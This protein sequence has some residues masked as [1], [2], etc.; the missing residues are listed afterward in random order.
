LL[1]GGLRW[2][3]LAFSL[4]G[5]RWRGFA[6]FILTLLVGLRLPLVRLIGLSFTLLGLALPGWRLTL[7]RLTLWLPLL[8]LARLRLARLRLAS[9]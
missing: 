5:F 7:L 2:L 9:L 8:R 4:L 1:S 6:S 3:V